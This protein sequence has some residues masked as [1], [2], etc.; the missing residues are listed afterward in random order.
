MIEV[1]PVQLMERIPSIRA[2]M[3]LELILKGYSSQLKYKV[4][5]D[6]GTNWLLRVS[7][8]DHHARMQ[9]EFNMIQEIHNHGVQCPE[10]VEIGRLDDLS[11]SYYILTYIDGDE[12]TEVLPKLP[13]NIQHQIG[14]SAGIDLRQMHTFPAP[15]WIRP[16]SKRC[17]EKFN[18]YVEVYRNCGVRLRHDDFILSLVERNSWLMLGRPS[19]FQ[20]DDFHVGNIIVQTDSYSG[21]IDFNRFDW[22]DPIHDFVKVAMF[23]R[24]VSVPF[25]IGQIEG[26][27]HGATVPETFWELYR[28]Y[29]AMTVVSSIVWTQRVVPH[30]MD[31]MIR[32]LNRVMEDHED[33]R[34]CKPTWFKP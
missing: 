8:L 3:G 1:T 31:K 15:T 29:L 18:K 12:A 14:V 20:H 4:I 30:E 33:F 2:C 10:A 26:Y 34:S 6:G 17:I 27:F 32:R 23:S 5:R 22:G 7:A 11:I 19:V 21:V 9:A 16:W 28:L 25:S 24:D 13:H